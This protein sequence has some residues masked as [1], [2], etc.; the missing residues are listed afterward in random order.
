MKKGLVVSGG[1][2]LGAYAG[3]VIEYLVKKEHKNWNVYSGASVGSLV[4]TVVGIQD[5][6]TLKDVFFEIDEPKDIFSDETFLFNKLNIF[7]LIYRIIT[8][9]SS[10]SNTKKIRKILNQ[11]ISETKYNKTENKIIA[12]IS[13]YNTSQVEYINNIAINYN[14]FLD[15]VWASTSIPIIMP[16]VIKKNNYYY[17]G[18]ILDALPI[19][20]V[21][22]EGCDEID[23][24]VLKPK[25]LKNKK[26]KPKSLSNI[27]LR[28][29][30]LMQH[31]Q[32]QQNIDITNL[33]LNKN[34]TLNFYYTPTELLEN[35]LEIHANTVRN[36]WLKGYETTNKKTILLKHK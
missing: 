16:P 6:N 31:R 22:N 7:N 1:G 24:I 12:S 10:L 17:D 25:T 36:L 15:Y 20:N 21:I 27:I 18:G 3:A 30:N 29:I 14:D 33:K 19:Q 32:Y 13:N 23:I 28:T 2:I 34:V 5:I 26:W 11:I 9:K 8:K 4:T 35:S